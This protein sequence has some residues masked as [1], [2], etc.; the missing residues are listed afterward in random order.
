MATTDQ[1]QAAIAQAARLQAEA[2]VHK[3]NAEFHRREAQR[4]QIELAQFIARCH[5]LG[6]TVILEPSATLNVESRAP[7]TNAEGGTSG[8]DQR[9]EAD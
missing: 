9:K 6:I 2:R 1:V 4:R 3:R 8:G 5:E 7:L